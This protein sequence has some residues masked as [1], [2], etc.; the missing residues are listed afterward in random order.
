MARLNGMAKSEMNQTSKTGASGRQV[1]AKRQPE[2][3]SP[4]G[5]DPALSTGLRERLIERMRDA[6]IPEGHPQ[7]LHLAA[8]TGR[9]YQTT[10]RWIDPATPGLPDLA[11]FRL[12]CTGMDGDPSWLL[13]L[14]DEKRSL[15]ES[16]AGA[17]PAGRESREP[18]DWVQGVTRDVQHQMFGCHARLMRGDEMEPDIADGDTIFVDFG[19]GEFCGNG[20]YLI[21]C[22]GL[23]LVRM[24]EYRVDI[25]L[26][27]RCANSNYAETV[28]RDAADSV[29]RKLKVLGRIEGVVQVRKF[30]KT[31]R[32]GAA[33]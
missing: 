21:A 33:G 9:T 3:A 16:V 10:R 13:G 32:A 24:L 1:Q 7:A 26:V 31:S 25:G 4:A 8:I 2:D 15:R 17:A 19:V 14:V 18:G 20:T 28:I 11:S 23:E 12:L 27:L 6:R 29:R 5:A 22:D 30:W